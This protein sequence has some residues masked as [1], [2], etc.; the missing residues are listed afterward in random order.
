MRRVNHSPA[1]G[2]SFSDN[3]VVVRIAVGGIVSS[4]DS[5]WVSILPTRE[6]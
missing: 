6:S 2:D 1:P 3:R 4:K 5:F